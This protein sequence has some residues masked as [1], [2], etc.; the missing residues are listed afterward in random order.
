MTSDR[1]TVA[2]LGCGPA[3]LLAAHACAM[4]EQPFT[5][6][7]RKEKSMIGGAQFLHSNIPGLTP[8]MSDSVVALI[9]QGTADGYRNKVYGHD[10]SGWPASVSFPTER[11]AQRAW[12]M[13]SAYD[14]L[15]DTYD[16]FILNEQVTPQMLDGLLDRFQFVVNT[17][18]AHAVCLTAQGA[19][20]GQCVFRTAEINILHGGAGDSLHDNTIVYDGTDDMAW[21]RA[22]KI[23]GHGFVEYGVHGPKPPGMKMVTVRKPISTTCDC[24]SQRNLLRAGRMGEWRK[25]VLVHDAYNKVSECLDGGM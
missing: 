22:S 8:P 20:P 19:R 9:P 5:L 17:V 7:S 14:I 24:W 23:F 4:A 25:G 11:T 16:H 6:I 21:A 13:Q 15:W 18:P 2:I 1:G 3:G 10:P 12:S